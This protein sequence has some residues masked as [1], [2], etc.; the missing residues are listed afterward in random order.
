[1]VKVYLVDDSVLFLNEL[2]LTVPWERMDCKVVGSALEAETA[3]RE[4]REM[5]PDLIITDISMPGRD[6][7][8]M[9]ESL[10]DIPGPEF[11][12]VSAYPKFEYAF[13]AIKLKTADYFVKPFDDEEF[14]RAIK[15]VAQR[16]SARQAGR[17]RRAPPAGN[18]FRPHAQRLHRSGAPV[19]RRPLCRRSFGHLCGESAV[20][21]GELSEQVLS[22][23]A[24][25][26]L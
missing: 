14:Y 15:R 17:R 7:L 12:I 16:I 13:R 2:T 6:G 3:E 1:M 22:P 18:L 10:A 5:R 23:R 21:L 4:I 26:V 9:V 24:E 20:H 19:C 25:H 11:I 8:A